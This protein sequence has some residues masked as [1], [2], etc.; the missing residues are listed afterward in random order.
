MKLT[1]SALRI[2]CNLN[3]LGQIWGM[4]LGQ[5]SNYCMWRKNFKIRNICQS[6]WL[7]VD[8]DKPHS[9]WCQRLLWKAPR[10]PPLSCR[11]LMATHT[12][13]LLLNEWWSHLLC[14]SDPQSQQCSNHS[15]KAKSYGCV[16]IILQVNFACN[17]HPQLDNN[18]VT[19]VV[20][21]DIWSP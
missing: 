16:C 13:L 2:L 19:L 8:M 10:C 3:K 4:I 5:L 15:L 7:C 14:R 11:L 18:F 1:R 21:L 20:G 6:K 17:L 9:S 12:T